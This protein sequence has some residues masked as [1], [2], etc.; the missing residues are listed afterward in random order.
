MKLTKYVEKDEKSLKTN[1]KKD[2]GVDVNASESQS[3]VP[4]PFH[5]VFTE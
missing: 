1:S 2:T 3:Q 4:F 5:N